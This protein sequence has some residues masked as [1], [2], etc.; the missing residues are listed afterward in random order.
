MLTAR[1]KPP[2]QDLIRQ[3]SSRVKPG[4]RI[5][6]SA[7]V[8]SSLG[9]DP[10]GGTSDGVGDDAF[11]DGATTGKKRN[12]EDQDRAHDRHDPLDACLALA[13]LHH[14]FADIST[15]AGASPTRLPHQWGSAAGAR[16]L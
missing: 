4:S 2:G 14:M 9:E 6:V 8:K 15:A 1:P 13:C 16:N 3:S 7:L 10:H 12:G 5:S 11:H